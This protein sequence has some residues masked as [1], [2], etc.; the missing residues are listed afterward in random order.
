MS[1]HESHTSQHESTQVKRCPRWVNI[2]QHKSDT[3][4]T[5]VNLS[6]LTFNI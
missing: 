4:L 5:Q 6:K 1:Q 2:S 3:S